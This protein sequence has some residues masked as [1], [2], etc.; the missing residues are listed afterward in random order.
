MITSPSRLAKAATAVVQR[1]AGQRRS[2][3]GDD[4]PLVLVDQLGNGQC[5][6]GPG[7]Y[8]A[9]VAVVQA[10]GLGCST[11]GAGNFAGTVVDVV[12]LECQRFCGADQTAIAVIEGRAGQA[13]IALG[14]Q[15]PALLL[16]QADVGCEIALAGDS[17]GAFCTSSAFR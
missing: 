4:Q 14:D 1:L 8:L 16:Q 7:Q 9:A 11:S 5:Q 10:S 2:A 12:D 17:P 3:L 6:I 15:F 13:Q